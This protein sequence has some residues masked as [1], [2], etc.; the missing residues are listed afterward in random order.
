MDTRVIVH[1]ELAGVSVRI[2]TSWARTR[3]GKESASFEYDREWLRHPTRFS[4]EPALQTGPGAFHT[5]AGQA[6]FGA[7]GDSAPD[8]WGRV[9]MRPAERRRAR[10]DGDAPRTLR[11]IDYLLT[12]N[13]ASRQGGRSDSPLRRGGLPCSTLGRRSLDPAVGR[14]PPSPLRGRAGHRRV[15]YR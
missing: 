8:R 1:V 10:K 6:M 11:E 2:G 13:D 5:T 4:L 14:A 15:G 3:K 9:L 12:V 7:I